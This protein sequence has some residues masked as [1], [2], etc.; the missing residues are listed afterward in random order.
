MSGT[1]VKI[2]S[3]N[4]VLRLTFPLF[5]YLIV[6]VLFS[7]KY[8]I[9]KT[10]IYTRN[11]ENF[12]TKFVSN[13]AKIDWHFQNANWRE[14]R[15]SAWKMWI[16]LNIKFL[17]NGCLIIWTF[18]ICW[19][20]EYVDSCLKSYLCPENLTFVIIRHSHVI[21]KK[22]TILFADGTLLVI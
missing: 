18:S 13:F 14:F 20:F 19:C 3:N 11:T 16:H 15:E 7:R 6:D 1:T 12:D 8:Y 5:N 4:F 22:Y 2:T 17:R 9:L 21:L 10:T